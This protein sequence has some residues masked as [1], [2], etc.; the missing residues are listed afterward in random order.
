[1]EWCSTRK[2]EK[3]T[4]DPR[5]T[6]IASRSALR[7]GFPLRKAQ[8]QDDRP[9]WDVHFHGRSFTYVWP[10]TGQTDSEK[11]GLELF[12]AALGF[13]HQLI[14]AGLVANA[15]EQRVAQEV[16][17]AKEAPLDGALQDVKPGGL[18]SQD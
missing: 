14:E 10:L 6:P 13:L 17:V 2:H 7:A 1:M 15:V 18:V 11:S 12:V 3:A 8:G 4:A 5:S 9:H 16:G